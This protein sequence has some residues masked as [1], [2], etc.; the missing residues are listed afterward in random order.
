[1]VGGVDQGLEMFAGLGILFAGQFLVEVQHQVHERDHLVILRCVGGIVEVDGPDGHLLHVLVDEP[2]AE[3]ARTHAKRDAY[4]RYEPPEQPAVEKSEKIAV[5]AVD[6]VSGVG[7]KQPA[8]IETKTGVFADV[9][10]HNLGTGKNLPVSDV[11]LNLEPLVS[12]RLSALFLAAGGL[13]R[14]IFPPLREMLFNCR[15]TAEV[16]S[17]SCEDQPF[18]GWVDVISSAIH[19]AAERKNDVG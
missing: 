2:V 14:Q 16:S 11:I 6:G 1:M 3:L 17:S 10:K 5:V 18:I 15:V 19:A 13:W 8:I 9:R 12:P 4:L 7:K